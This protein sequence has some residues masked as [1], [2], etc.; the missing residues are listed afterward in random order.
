VVISFS[1]SVFFLHIDV[2]AGN[3]VFS[4]RGFIPAVTFPIGGH[5]LPR[6]DVSLPYDFVVAP[7]RIIWLSLS[8]ADI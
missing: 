2:G 4:F 1:R 6:E 7:L 5:F 3:V 8:T